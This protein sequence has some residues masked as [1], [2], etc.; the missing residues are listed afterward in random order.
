MYLEILLPRFAHDH[1]DIEIRAHVEKSQ[2]AL[3]EK[4]EKRE[5]DIV[6][7]PDM[8][9]FSGH[10][11]E[12]LLK[13]RVCLS[14]PDSNP[15]SEKEE[16]TVVD[17]KGQPFIVY[18]DEGYIFEKMLVR[19]RKNMR[20]SYM[21]DIPLSSLKFSDKEH[22]FL[23]T[24]LSRWFPIEEIKRKTVPIKGNGAEYKVCAYYNSESKADL[25]TF[26]NWLHELLSPWNER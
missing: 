19:Q 5:V 24:I 13:E 4:L 15:L 2:S 17:L 10:E 16:L 11:K 18:D 12:V 6:I 20:V 9:L 25:D 21:S 3:H 7:A 1:P 8:D 22:L 14:V 26:L 23:D